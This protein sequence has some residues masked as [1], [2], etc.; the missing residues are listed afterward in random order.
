MQLALSF[1]RRTVLAGAGARATEDALIEALARLRDEARRDPRILA[2]PVRIVVPSRSLR[3]HLGATL[4]RRLGSALVGVRIQTLHGLALELLEAELPG[5]RQGGA[6]QDAFALRLARQTDALRPLADAYVDGHQGIVEA[7]RQLLDAG[8]V[9]EHVEIA[10]DCLEGAEHIA[11]A[12][13]DR[14]IAAVRVAAG[15]ERLLDT[16]GLLTPAAVMRKAAE[17]LVRLGADGLPSHTLFLHGFADATGVA[18]DLLEQL[19]RVPGAIV[20]V[21]QPPDPATPAVADA[22]VRLSARLRERMVPAD[23]ERIEV[24]VAQSRIEVFAA[25]GDGEMAE[26][27]RRI[28]VL[29]DDGVTPESIG[30]VARDLDARAA[31]I[32][33]HF[34]RHAIPYSGLD[35]H[36]PDSPAARWRSLPDLL[37]ERARLSVDRWLELLGA[38]DGEPLEGPRRSKMRLCLRGAGC[39]QVAHVATLDADVLLAGKGIVVLPGALGLHEG[40][41]VRP[42]LDERW[43]RATIAAAAQYV[44]WSGGLPEKAARSQWEAHVLT[45]LVLL[46]RPERAE[47]LAAIA[48]VPDL[49]LYAP[50]FAILLTDTLDEQG[51]SRLGG[52]GGGVQVLSVREARARTFAHLFLV[53]QNRRSGSRRDAVLSE[54]V[55]KALRAVLPDLPVARD[56]FDEDR[57]HFAWLCSA[58]P[59]VT[60]SWQT[61]DARGKLQSL[62]PL[63]ERLRWAGVWSVATI[64]ASAWSAPL[65]ARAAPADHAIVAGLAGGAAFLERPLRAALVAAG[66]PGAT[67]VAR[68]Q[69]AALGEFDTRAPTPGP[70]LGAVGAPVVDDP[71][72]RPLYVSFAE[73]YLRCPWKG[74][75]ERHLGVEPLPDPLEAVPQADQRIVGN[76]VHAVLERIAQRTLSA[77]SRTV[78]H[79]LTATPTLLPWPEPDVLTALVARE[80]ATILSEEGV[81]L[82]G[83]AELLARRVRP[84]ID[85]AHHIDWRQGPP[86]TLGAEV[87]GWFDIDGKEVRFRADRVDRRAPDLVLT[88]YKTGKP[89][90][91]QKGADARRNAYVKEV[92]KGNSLQAAAYAAS[93]PGAVGRLVYLRPELAPEFK[94]LE[95]WDTDHEAR[96]ALQGALGAALAGVAAGVFFPRLS[97]PDDDKEPRTCRS[98]EVREACLHGDS[99]ARGRLRAR[100][101]MLRTAEQAGAALSPADAAQNVV[102]WLPGGR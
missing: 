33:R 65:G 59:R 26:V 54:E 9:A 24:Q 49:E 80:A 51:R 93:A 13:R 20:T 10:A 57:L 62:S 100:A 56:R 50:E 95:I 25:E 92:A 15:T 97:E 73:Q 28:G 19:A 8:L 85:E 66:V 14:A 47:S 21:D 31:S 79:A 102:W 74:F 12:E 82:P 22:G 70:Y 45:L 4:P 38:L 16:L 2:R 37:V 99:T 53:G 7:V 5:A 61:T 46:G 101:S 81:R 84:M 89:L 40:R 91:D 96:E 18:A 30:I 60:L 55:R 69:L 41:A 67:A 75:L 76:L 23:A 34:D 36:A 94:S 32:R 29:L 90:A 39:T 6:L 86:E 77:G 35:A 88:D 71:R 64:A 17:L 58:A 63:V 87:D 43:L 11:P 1:R 83:L 48:E 52:N 27:A 72:H 68:A 78:A 3:L 42:S 98:C 44:A